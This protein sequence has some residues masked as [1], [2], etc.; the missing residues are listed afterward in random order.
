[1][2]VPNK[3]VPSSVCKFI[4]L[5]HTESTSLPDPDN[6]GAFSGQIHH[7]NMPIQIYNENFTTKK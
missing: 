6:S 4:V 3:K 2:A 5:G 7:E 1:M